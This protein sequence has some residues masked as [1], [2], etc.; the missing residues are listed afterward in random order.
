VQ[1][2]DKTNSVSI[3]A[4]HYKLTIVGPNGHHTRVVVEA[5]RVCYR[6]W[7]PDWK[8]CGRRDCARR[9]QRPQMLCGIN[10]VTHYM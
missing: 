9:R 10:R 8:R 4:S 6:R 3:G 2:L 5:R 7:P 1:H